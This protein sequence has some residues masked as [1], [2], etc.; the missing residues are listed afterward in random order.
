MPRIY[1]NAITCFSNFIDLVLILLILYIIIEI[2]LIS[3]LIIKGVINDLLIIYL[4]F[5][6]WNNKNKKIFK[7]LYL[8]KFFQ[9]NFFKKFLTLNL[10]IYIYLEIFKNF[11][12]NKK[13]FSAWQIL[14]L[15][16][17]LLLE[18]NIFYKFFN[19]KNPFSTIY[20]NKKIKYSNWYWKNRY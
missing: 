20:K 4:N 10:N 9:K 12:F 17:N 7:N 8:L 16:S 6:K 13:L 5:Y 18:K 14:K 15:I 19:K 2:L 1:S 11:F 3:F